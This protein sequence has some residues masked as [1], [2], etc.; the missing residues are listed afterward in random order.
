MQ[1]LPRKPKGTRIQVHPLI[2]QDGQTH[3]GDEPKA[4][5]YQ[6]QAFLRRETP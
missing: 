5:Q 3:I 1:R 6:L 4:S 2:N